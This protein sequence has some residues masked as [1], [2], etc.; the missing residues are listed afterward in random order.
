MLLKQNLFVSGEGGYHSYRIPALVLAANGD[1]LAFCEGRRDAR[2][3]AGKIDLLLRR[4]AD[5]GATWSEPAVVWADGE[6]TCGNPCP[7]IDPAS[8]D[9]LLFSTW[10]LGTDREKAIVARES[11]DTR[12]VFLLRSRNHGKTWGRAKEITA[13]VKPPEWTWYATG[14]GAG[15]AIERG[16]RKGRLVIPCDHIEAEDRYSHAIISDDGGRT[17]RVGGRIGPGV[18]ECEAVELT[19]GRLLMNMRNHQRTETH[20]KVAFSADGGETWTEPQSDPVLIE[21]VC[22][23]SIRR[24]R[25]PRGKRPGV[26]LFSNPACTFSGPDKGRR[27]MVLRASFDE[28]RTWPVALVLHPGLAAYSDL[29]VAAD[30]AICCLYEAGE[31]HYWERIVLARVGPEEL[32]MRQRLEANGA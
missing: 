2:G 9:V 19:A 25:W 14:P 16:P 15:L 26:I 30:G 20:R 3:D 11:Q 13:D 28:A 8:G 12:R 10:N 29:A 22:Q 1:L 6:N 17:W 32:G 27:N 18:N 24:T 4:S 31:Q 21:P 7:V 5:D 23:A